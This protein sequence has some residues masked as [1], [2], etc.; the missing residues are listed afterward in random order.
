MPVK[1]KFPN[2][3]KVLLADVDEEDA[4]TLASFLELSGFTVRRATEIVEALTQFS[5]FSPGIVLIDANLPAKSW[6][7]LIQSIRAYEVEKDSDY[8]SIILVTASKYTTDL[9]QRAAKAG[10]HDVIGKPVDQQGLLKKI[11]EYTAIY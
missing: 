11:T 7:Q 2:A 10:A 9:H 1:S 6:L 8:R 4:L 5:D 3:D